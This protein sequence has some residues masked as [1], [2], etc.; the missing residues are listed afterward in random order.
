MSRINPT[1]TVIVPVY[2][3]VERLRM[4]LVAL[5]TQ[6]YDGD[7][8]IVVADNASTDDIATAIPGGD[9][10][11]VVVREMKRGSYAARNAAVRQATGSVLAFTDADCIPRSDWLT[12]A[13]STLIDEA[14]P[15]DAVGGAINLLY[16]HP[17]GPTTGPELFEYS[18][19]GFD[20]ELY[21]SKL[22]FSATANLVVWR[23][24]FNAVG[25]F[26][27]S[28]QSGGDLEWGQRLHKMGLRMNYSSRAVVDH[29]SRPS[30]SQLTA[31]TLRIANGRVDLM[32]Q[33][34]A[35]PF[36]ASSWHDQRRTFTIWWSVW[37]ADWP[38][39]RLH[40]LRL[41]AARS[42]A[43]LLELGVRVRRRA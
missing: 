21:V 31:K 35:A 6:D 2:N 15:T 19:G 5:A 16:R 1:V 34:E 25:E 23:R 12:N 17:A 13:V 26:D 4:C 42:Y 14:D 28:L 22:H 8:D 29:P 37:K 10:R 40:K 36:L 27:P 9:P 20:Q 43:G 41:A 3:D 38:G 18:E 7:F 39:S 30:W 32:R 33:A 11:F 24:V